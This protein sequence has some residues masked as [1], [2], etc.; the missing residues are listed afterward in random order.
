[1]SAGVRRGGGRGWGGRCGRSAGGLLQAWTQDQAALR[2]F[3]Q[4]AW[5]GFGLCLEPRAA[6]EM[7]SLPVLV[8]TEGAAVTCRITAAARLARLP[9][10]VPAALRT[11]ERENHKLQSLNITL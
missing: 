2:S 6:D 7:V 8:L 11:R 9:T 4:D 10:A 3:G 5:H 1:M